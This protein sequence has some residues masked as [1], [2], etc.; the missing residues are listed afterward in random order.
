MFETFVVLIT[1]HLLSDFIFQ[2]NWIA[3]RKIN[4]NV[5]LLHLAII[6]VVTA[7]LL[8]DLHLAILGTIVVT[9]GL[10]DFVKARFLPDTLFSFMFDQAVH[11]GVLAALALAY[12][13]AYADGVWPIVLGPSDALYLKAAIV[14]AGFILCVYTGAHAIRLFTAPFRAELPEDQFEGLAKGGLYIGCLERAV[15]FIFVIAGQ[16]LSVGFLITAKSLLRFGDI[17]DADHRKM[18]EYIIIGTFASFGWALLVSS[19]AMQVLTP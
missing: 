10:M 13:G 11:I 2:S 9:H 5:L 15:V 12:P 18:A 16:T 8:G 3:T 6:F 1:A 14:V 7:C 19:L 4:L 17:K